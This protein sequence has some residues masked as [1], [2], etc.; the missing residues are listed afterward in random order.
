MGFR[1]YRTKVLAAFAAAATV[2]IMGTGPAAAATSA[3]DEVD[4]S[5][6]LYWAFVNEETGECLA[7]YQS[8]AIRSVSCDDKGQAGQWHWI[9]SEWNSDYRLLKNRWT[10]KCLIGT[11]PVTSGNCEDWTS[12]HWDNRA[13]RDS[14]YLFNAEKSKFL[15]D[16]YWGENELDLAGWSSDS[17]ILWKMQQVVEVRP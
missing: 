11:N 8:G 10:G 13:W 17:N 15:R 7:T 3:D 9:R 16:A 6:I 2:A 14:Y 1:R 4:A 5:A 12:R